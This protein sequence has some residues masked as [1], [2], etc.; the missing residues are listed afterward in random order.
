[1]CQVLEQY[2][3]I[4]SVRMVRDIIKMKRRRRN[5]N[6]KQNQRCLWTLKVKP[7]MGS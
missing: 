3:P 5:K 2:K 7:K 6:R 1:M 4:A